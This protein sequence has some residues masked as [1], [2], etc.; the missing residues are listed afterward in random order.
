MCCTISDDLLATYCYFLN[1]SIFFQ[2]DSTFLQRPQSH[3]HYYDKLESKMPKLTRPLI[4]LLVPICLTLIR[5]SQSASVD[6]ASGAGLTKFQYYEAFERESDKNV[7]DLMALWKARLDYSQNSFIGSI[8]FSQRLASIIH[9]PDSASKANYTRAELL[10]GV[11]LGLGNSLRIDLA[12]GGFFWAMNI[13]DKSYGVEI[14]HGPL[15]KLKINIL[16][17]KEPLLWLEGLFG[18]SDSPTE[19][20]DKEV[21]LELGAVLTNPKKGVKVLAEAH[22]GIIRLDQVRA[23]RLRSLGG[24]IFIKFAILDN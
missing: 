6:L 18:T 7:S 17:S 3:R 2:L 1:K 10:G 14:Q 12:G 19:L 20:K 15:I 9:A 22:M 11:K 8:N 21:K 5:S 13:P 4:L 24:G 16:E 23:T